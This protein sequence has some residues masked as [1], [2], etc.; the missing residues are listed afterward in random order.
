MLYASQTIRQKVLI[1]FV[2]VLAAYQSRALGQDPLPSW[3][4]GDAKARILQFVKEATDKNGAHF[5]PEEERVA[6]FDQD[7]T[8]W[9]E[10]PVYPQFFFALDRFKELYP[11]HPEWQELDLAIEKAKQAG[12][13]GALSHEE[14]LRV[15]LLTHSGMTIDEFQS[16]VKKWLDTARH[17][18]YNRPFTDLVYQPMLEVIR[19]LKDNGFKVYIVS[20]GGQEFMRTYAEKIYGIPPEQVIGSA[21]KVKYKYENGKPVLV[22]LPDVLIVDDKQGKADDINLFIGRRPVAAFG[23]SDG[24]KEM[25]EWS[26]SGRPPRLEVLIHHDDPVR[27]YAY[28]ADSKV[29][30]FSDALMQEASKKNWVVVSMKNDWKA[31]FPW[32]REDACGECFF[33]KR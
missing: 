15:I 21:E 14:A 5:V 9:V 28:G 8:L 7:G 30:T 10:Q 22:R 2:F 23:N 18:R 16:L 26:Q 6:T 25:L 31:V 20:G 19:L 3:N 29:G 4:Q 33:K 24:D 1:L 11:E 13:P 17:P 12:H 27:E 32:Q